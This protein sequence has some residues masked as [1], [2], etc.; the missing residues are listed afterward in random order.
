MRKKR[1]E[2]HEAYVTTV[3][4]A[5]NRKSLLGLY[6]CQQPEKTKFFV[7]TLDAGNCFVWGE[8]RKR[9][10]VDGAHVREVVHS[11]AAAPPM[12]FELTAL[13]LLWICQYPATARSPVS[14]VIVLTA[15]E[16][17]RTEVGLIFLIS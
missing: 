13:H 7:R 11:A 6:S 12:H 4:S 5:P 10:R 9:G 15:A 16:R 8:R 17:T 1:H 3:S 14:F 2:A